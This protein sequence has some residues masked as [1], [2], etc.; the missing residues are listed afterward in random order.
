MLY[1][2]STYDNLLAEL[3]SL[4]FLNP[5]IDD[6]QLYKLVKQYTIIGTPLVIEI[7]RNFF[8]NSRYEIEK[9]YYDINKEEWNDYTFEEFFE[10]L[11]E[12][13]KERV[14]FHLD[15]FG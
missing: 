10:K 9:I 14:I 2:D 3:D 6:P 15:L 12:E 8:T 5:T 7:S 1:D 11:P 13:I 4:D